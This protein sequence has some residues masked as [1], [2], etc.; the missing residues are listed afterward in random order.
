MISTD[1]LQFSTVKHRVLSAKARSPLGPALLFPECA[2]YHSPVILGPEQLG[3]GV[4]GERVLLASSLCLPETC[5]IRVLLWGNVGPVVVVGRDSCFRLT[6]RFIMPRGHYLPWLRLAGY[7]LLRAAALLTS[8]EVRGCFLW[9]EEDA[10]DEIFLSEELANQI[11]KN[12]FLCDSL[13]FSSF[14]SFLPSFFHFFSSSPHTPQ[15]RF[16]LS[17]LF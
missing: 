16:S 15:P 3:A 8:A 9:A 13:L 14:L 2:P 4:S 17:F 11:C 12:C 7:L 10:A 1:S 5:R 6:G